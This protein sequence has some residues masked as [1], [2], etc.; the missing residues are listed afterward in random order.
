MIRRLTGDL[1][2]PEAIL[3]AVVIAACATV[4]AMLGLQ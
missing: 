4:I 3:A 2:G 1:T